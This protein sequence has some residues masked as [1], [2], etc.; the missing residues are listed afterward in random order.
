MK[1]IPGDENKPLII[2]I[3][4][5]SHLARIAYGY[6]NCNE[7][8]FL[9]YWIHQKQYPFLAISYPIENKVFNQVY[10]D[11]SITDWSQSVIQITKMIIAKNHLSNQ[12]IILGWSMAGEL[13]P[14]LNLIAA[15]NNVNIKLFIAM[16]ASQP[17]Y[18]FYNLLEPDSK[19]MA[20]IEPFFSMFYP[21]LNYQN[22]IN[23][24]VI[25]PNKIYR[26]EFLGNI[27]V[28]LIGSNFRYSDNGFHINLNEAVEDTSALNP[29]NYP[30]IAV[31]QGNYKYDFDAIYNQADWSSIIRR[32]YLMEDS[33]CLKPFYSRK[34][35]SVAEIDKSLHSINDLFI[36]VPGSHFFFIGKYGAKITANSIEKLITNSSHLQP[37]C[38][39]N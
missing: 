16:S 9:A 23:H 2:F 17:M 37:I 33:D 38:I 26:E 19:K 18:N 1:F 7:Q 34:K 30:F 32:Q 10:P 4:G 29:G 20:N 14:K 36:T 8:D 27:P 31:L 13:A 35:L 39:T 24:H 21:L 6:P 22:R 11:Y 5:M 3:P 12:V 28:D 25:I 15:K